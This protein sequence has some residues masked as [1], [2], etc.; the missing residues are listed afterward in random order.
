MKKPVLTRRML[1][2]MIAV[3]VPAVSCAPRLEP[4]VAGLRSDLAKVSLAYASS[5]RIPIGWKALRP[6]EPPGAVPFLFVHLLDQS[7]QLVRTFDRQIQDI[8]Q[9]GLL[10]KDSTEIDDLVE[11]WQSALAEPLPVGSYRLILGIYDAASGQRWRL[12]TS[13]NAIVEGAYEIAAIQV[14]SAEKKTPDLVFG[15]DWL[16]PDEGQLHNPG[17]RWMGESGSIRLFGT[18]GWSGVVLNLSIADLSADRHLPVFEGAASEPRL[19]IRNGCDRDSETLVEG[20][21]V[22]SVSLRIEPG[23]DCAITFEPNF[24]MLALGDFTRRSI[25]LESVFFRPNARVG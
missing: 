14:E 9:V 21:G 17:R 7:G 24:T 19:V 25:G 22:H 5:S 8:W 18:A 6:L 15:G 11:I 16:A 23:A 3:A 4:P 10:P 12:E 2:L 20:Y 13:A 1:F